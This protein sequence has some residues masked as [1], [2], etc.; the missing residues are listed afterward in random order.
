MYT[1]LMQVQVYYLVTFSTGSTNI[2]FSQ[3]PNNNQSVVSKPKHNDKNTLQNTINE[4]IDAGTWVETLLEDKTVV[5][6]I[7]KN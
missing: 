1:I 6:K 3:H 5:E 2:S 4:E 7:K